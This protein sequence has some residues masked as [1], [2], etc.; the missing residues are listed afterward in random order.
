[1]NHSLRTRS[2]LVRAAEIGL[3]VRHRPATADGIVFAEET[4]AQKKLRAQ[5][6]RDSAMIFSVC[7]VII[8]ALLLVQ[9]IAQVMSA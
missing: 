7:A 8:G 3:M 5:R 1:M 2:A 9:F 4:G 6:R